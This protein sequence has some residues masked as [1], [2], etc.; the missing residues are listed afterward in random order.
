MPSLEATK[1]HFGSRGALVEG[2]GD[3]PT[4]GISRIVLSSRP[5]GFIRVTAS[6][7]C[8]QDF[9]RVF[10]A[11]NDVDFVGQ[12]QPPGEIAVAFV[13][14]AKAQRAFSGDVTKQNI[15]LANDRERVKVV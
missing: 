1:F 9:T 4:T 6:E 2:F 7:Y 3:G 13:A 15:R 8:V 14:V 12:Q 5:P 11:G 10:G